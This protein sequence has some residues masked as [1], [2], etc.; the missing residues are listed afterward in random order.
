MRYIVT[1]GAGFIGSELCRSL[2]QNYSHEVLCLDNLSYSS[3]LNAISEIKENKNFH[4][5][6]I[7]ICD[8]DLIY[9]ELANFKPDGIFNLAAQTHVDRSMRFPKRI[10]NK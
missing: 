3:N 4:F 9:H 1:G 10:Y 6:K 7:D 5:K 8:E 2:V